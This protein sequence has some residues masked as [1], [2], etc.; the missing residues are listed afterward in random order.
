M[1]AEWRA[2]VIL[3]PF[4]AHTLTMA[5]GV[6]SERVNLR[7]LVSPEICFSMSVG[8]AIKSSLPVYPSMS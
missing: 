5:E 8:R 2:A 1:R 3:Y 7:S 6:V 4:D